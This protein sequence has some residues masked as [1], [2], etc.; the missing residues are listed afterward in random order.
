MRRTLNALRSRKVNAMTTNRT[1]R[2]TKTAQTKGS[3][4]TKRVALASIAVCVFILSHSASGHIF[5]DTDTDSAGESSGIGMSVYA[6][7]FGKTV[8]WIEP[9]DSASAYSK[10]GAGWSFTDSDEAGEYVFKLSAAAYAQAGDAEG[11]DMEHMPY[12]PMYAYWAPVLDLS[13]TW[14]QK[15][16]RTQP[17]TCVASAYVIEPSSNPDIPPSESSAQLHKHRAYAKATAEKL[18]GGKKGTGLVPAI[19]ETMDPIEAVVKED[20]TIIELKPITVNPK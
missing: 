7:M 9:T 15:L 8:M 10:A 4:M 3:S 18:S 5:N 2:T 1:E 19:L 13:G 12:V 11:F 17:V 6:N 14:K 16:I 20:R